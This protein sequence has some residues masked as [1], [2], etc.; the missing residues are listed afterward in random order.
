MPIKLILRTHANI[1]LFRDIL[2]ETACSKIGDKILI[3]SGFFQ[4]RANYSAELEDNFI[5]RFKLTKKSIIT[6]GIHNGTW[7]KD[8]ERFVNEFKNKGISITSYIYSG[9]RWH[10]KIYLLLENNIPIFGIIGSSNIT[11]NA[12]SLSAPFNIESD[13]ILW[14]ENKKISNIINEKFNNIDIN[15]YYSLD[16]NIETNKNVTIKDRL[17]YLYNDIMKLSSKFKIV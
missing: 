3:C 6:I 15:N 13:V 7:K 5:D 8:Y 12:F 17:E 11:R 10:S 1:N 4:K 2:I 14:E 9:Y 16:Y